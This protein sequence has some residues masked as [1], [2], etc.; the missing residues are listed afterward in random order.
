MD[1]ISKDRRS[2]N[3]SAIKNSGTKPEILMR[4]YL[5]QAGVRYRCNSKSLPGKPDVSAKKWK[6]A[7]NVHG[8]FWH[9]HKNCK[10]FRLPKSNVRFWREKIT[11][12]RERDTSNRLDLEEAG[13]RYFEIWQCEIERGDL[14]KLD[15]FISEY[16]KARG[17]D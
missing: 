16:W 1:R 8:C 4:K 11:R 2:K 14:E 6:L 17:I 5:T 10:N 12:N 15:E 9:G 3:M 13:F 7:V